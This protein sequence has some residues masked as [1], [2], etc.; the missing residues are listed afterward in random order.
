MEGIPGAQSWNSWI[1]RR[2]G[3][4]Y[5]RARHPATRVRRGID[6]KVTPYP[7]R[8]SRFTLDGLEGEIMGK[9]AAAIHLVGG[10]PKGI[11]RV[12][13]VRRDLGRYAGMD[14]LDYYGSE[15]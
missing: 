1:C 7:L 15:F 12:R 8:T 13:L 5:T 9:Q 14:I 6:R 3:R 11:L 4:D 10:G 2:T